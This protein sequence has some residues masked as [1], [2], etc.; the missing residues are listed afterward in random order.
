MTTGASERFRSHDSNAPVSV[1]AHRIALDTSSQ[2]RERKIPKAKVTT[3]VSA[4]AE[5]PPRHRGAAAVRAGGPP[6]RCPSWAAWRAARAAQQ[7]R[8]RMHAHTP[9][10]APP[11]ACMQG[12]VTFRGRSMSENVPKH[13]RFG[14]WLGRKTPEHRSGKTAN[15]PN[16]HHMEPQRKSGIFNPILHE[17]NLKQRSS[18]I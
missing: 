7:M 4:L 12:A 14:R 1:V 8:L 18:G 10:S 9:T 15:K 11:H 3:I 6:R 16:I 13:H 17:Q 2:L 5:G